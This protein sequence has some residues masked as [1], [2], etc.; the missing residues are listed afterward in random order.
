M[1]RPNA[2]NHFKCACTHGSDARAQKGNTF[3][4]E[5]RKGKIITIEAIGWNLDLER[6]MTKD[7]EKDIWNPNT[8]VVATEY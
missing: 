7:I 2:S 4:K 6:I 8:N 5:I 1:W 3:K